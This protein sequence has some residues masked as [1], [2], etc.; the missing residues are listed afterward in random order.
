MLTYETFTQELIYRSDIVFSLIWR[1]SAC[2]ILNER[3]VVPLTTGSAIVQRMS[4]TSAQ[5]SSL[6]FGHLYF[7]W[8]VPL[9]IHS[10]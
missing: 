7:V 4:P 9:G 6:C 2:P 5:S 10:F 8:F 1:M 3:S